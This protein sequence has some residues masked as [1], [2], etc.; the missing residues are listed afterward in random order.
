MNSNKEADIGLSVI[1]MN[2]NK[3]SDILTVLFEMTM[4][5]SCFAAI[6]MPDIRLQLLLTAALAVTFGVIR[7]RSED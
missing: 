6:W 4:V 3:E 7:Y 1:N 2:S 5:I